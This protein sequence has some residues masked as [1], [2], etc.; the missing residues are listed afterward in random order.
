MVFYFSQTHDDNII[1]YFVHNGQIKTVHT[2]LGVGQIEHAKELPSYVDSG[3]F[4]LTALPASSTDYKLPGFSDVWNLSTNHRLH[5][6][7]L[8]LVNITGIIDT[9]MNIEKFM[10]VSVDKFKKSIETEIR[11]CPTELRNS[12]HS[13]SSLN[14]N[15]LKSFVTSQ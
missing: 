12:L 11:I 6:D 1:I 2:K 3:L 10:F 14:W 5:Q 9:S 15:T 13:M 8:V 4:R 7:N